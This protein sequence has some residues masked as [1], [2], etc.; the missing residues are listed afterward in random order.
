MSELKSK[1][2]EDVK[3][4]MKARNQHTVTTLRGLLAAVKQVEVDTRTEVD[5][6]KLIQIIQ[7]EIKM[8]RDALS[9]AKEQ[10]RSDLVEQNESEVAL[11]QNYLGK[12]LTED[13]LKSIITTLISEGN[14]NIGK[15]MGGLNS[16]YKGQFEGKVA[17]EVIKAC[18]GN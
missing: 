3:N 16:K 6:A 17:S 12:Q 10:N 8:R 7:K 14:D 2:N 4:A 5:D 11:L 9:F 1:I 13:E 15:I 18:L